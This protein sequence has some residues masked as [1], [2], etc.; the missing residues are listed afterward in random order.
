MSNLMLTEEEE[1]MTRQLMDHVAEMPETFPRISNKL[2]QKFLMARK[3]EM[4]RAIELFKK[5]VQVYR[6]L[7]LLDVSAEDEEVMAQLLSGKFILPGTRDDEGA[8]VLVFDASK[9]TPEAETHHATLCAIVF[10]LQALTDSTETQRNGISFVY[11]LTNAGWANTDYA[12]SRQLLDILTNAFPGRLRKCVLL[13][14]PTWFRYTFKMASAF[15]SFKQ[16]NKARFVSSLDGILDADVLP[17]CVPGGSL[18]YTP[19]Q[20]KAH[21]EALIQRRRLAWLCADPPNPLGAEDAGDEFVRSSSTVSAEVLAMVEEDQCRRSSL[22]S[23][24]A[25]GSP[26]ARLSS[27]SARSSAS[28]IKNNP[29][30][31]ELLAELDAEV[32]DAPPA[33]P[34]RGPPATTANTAPTRPAPN[35]NNSGTH[36]PASKLQS[37]TT[38]KTSRTLIPL[39]Q[40]EEEMVLLF[41]SGGII[42]HFSQLQ[43]EPYPT[44][45]SVAKHVSNVPKNRYSNVLAYDHSRVRLPDSEAYINANY[46]DGFR[47][48]KAYIA[49][50]GPLPSTFE[51]FWS[52]VW[53]ERSYIIVMATRELE[54]GRMKCHRYWPNPGTATEYGPFRVTGGSVA[55][56]NSQV[57]VRQFLIE[58]TETGEPPR[59]IVQFQFIGWPDHGVPETSE[60]VLKM[61][62]K[63]E[64]LQEGLGAAGGP[65]VVHCSAGIGRTGTF[66]TIDINL[67]RAA[68]LGN[69]DV[70]ETVR[71]LRQ[72]RWGMIQTPQQYQF[73]YLAIAQAARAAGYTSSEA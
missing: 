20:H 72:Q 39:T 43:S 53:H 25:A 12:L 60:S 7:D 63:V 61:L 48:K 41:K 52:M 58:N 8:D 15:L 56:G 37:S 11:D 46:I 50:Q 1:A 22:R 18:P 54:K 57:V 67:K 70:Y 3:W 42:N 47:Q 71:Q 51:D 59:A 24:L 69:V 40:L 34:P 44:D 55:E 66:I 4:T 36:R 5:H 33:P 31:S 29:F 32:A 21:I 35:G 2:A 64:E 62:S 16:F 27:G 73:C 68:V 13:N 6:T 9:H 38:A 28:S 65:V 45:F 30:A 49:A 19:E 14:A 17:D 26:L 23:Q 10:I